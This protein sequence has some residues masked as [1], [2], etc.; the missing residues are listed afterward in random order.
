MVNF[1]PSSSHSCGRGGRDRGTNEQ[2]TSSHGKG[3]SGNKQGQISQV[4]SY[5]HLKALPLVLTAGSL[6]RVSGAL[7]VSMTPPELLRTTRPGRLVRGRGS[8][9]VNL[10]EP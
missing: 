1:V 8:P 2:H 3:A 5:L 4:P 7:Q 10:P 6:E 9:L